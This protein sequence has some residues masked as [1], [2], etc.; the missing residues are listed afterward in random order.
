MPR[1]LTPARNAAP[2]EIGN[3]SIR[4]FYCGDTTNKSGAAK[5]APASDGS[6]FTRPIPTRRRGPKSNTVVRP[7]CVEPSAKGFVHVALALVLLSTNRANTRTHSGGRAS[8]RR[9]GRWADG[10]FESRR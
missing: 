1:R 8:E 6:K 7:G 10:M 9:R 2:D 4:P 5:R 3:V